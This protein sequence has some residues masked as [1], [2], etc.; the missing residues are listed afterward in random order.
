MILKFKIL[1]V[2]SY[3]VGFLEVLLL[4]FNECGFFR[5][6]FEIPFLVYEISYH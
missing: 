4:S 6:T 2:L 1:K 5:I 3:S